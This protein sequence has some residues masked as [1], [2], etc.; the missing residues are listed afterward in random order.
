MRLRL[1]VLLLLVSYA[2]G[3]QVMTHEEQLVRTTYA[4]LSYAAQV[5]DIHN[6]WLEKGHRQTI[7]PI[8]F[9]VRM[10]QQLLFDLTQF[11]V[12]RSLKFSPSITANW[13]PSQVNRLTCCR[14]PVALAAYPPRINMASY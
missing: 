9:K 2:K 4:R 10:D 12:G 1:I 11:K 7:D 8:Q 14:F 6:L 5:N 3:Q 13:L